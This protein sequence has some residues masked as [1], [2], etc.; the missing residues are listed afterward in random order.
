MPAYRQTKN[1]KPTKDCPMPIII[2]KSD[3]SLRSKYTPKIT[4]D[5]GYPMC[6]YAFLPILL[7]E[8]GS[9]ID[10]LSRHT[11]L[12]TAVNGKTMDKPGDGCYLP[13]SQSSIDTMWGQVMA[14]AE[15]CALYTRPTVR[16]AWTLVGTD[17]D[18]A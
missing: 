9:V 4:D 1:P 7:K 2:N 17:P 15:P 14:F 3:R 12:Y 11:K 18:D 13:E 5:A 10:T 6:Y 16:L 8:D